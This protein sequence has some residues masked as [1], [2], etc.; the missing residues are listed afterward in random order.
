[1]TNLFF[2]LSLILVLI[3]GMLY[4]K[5]LGA[6]L[7]LRHGTLSHLVRI[8]ILSIAPSLPIYTADPNLLYLMPF[9]FGILWFCIQGSPLARLSLLL[10]LYVISVALSG[11]TTL[12]APNLS[13]HLPLI[14][15]HSFL[16]IIQVFILL[17]LWLL[18]RYLKICTSELPMLSPPLWRVSLLMSL[19]TFS[20][21][22][23]CI[24]F[25]MLQPDWGESALQ[26]AFSHF[27]NLQTLLM[28][29]AIL[30]SACIN[31][32]IIRLL[33]RHEQLLQ[34]DMLYEVNRTYYDQLEQSQLAVRRLRHDLAN[35][36]QTMRELDDASL[37]TYI[38]ALIDTPA[39]QAHTVYCENQIV[40]AVLQN[41]MPQMEQ[42]QITAQ[43]VVSIPKH[44][45]IQPVDLCALF[46][47]GLD[48]AIEACALL[49][50][51]ER[52][53]SVHA[54]A[55]KGLFVLR[56]CNPTV[57]HSPLKADT[58]PQSSKADRI[59]HGHGLPSLQ[60]ISMRY[61]GTFHI[62]RKQGIF[63]LLITIPLAQKI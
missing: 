50:F 48:N 40:N 56:I 63:E 16:Y 47:N 27:F 45:P 24:A 62:T 28:T 51:S 43:Y 55:D 18:F 10:N 17:M 41:K 58:L 13:S 6:F 19:F 12:L 60:E 3:C 57:D 23:L 30:L 15:M 44:L 8:L 7:P 4:E 25:P 36:L 39:M 33:S 2:L 31:L 61:D 35:H 32:Y 29:P 21:L 46:A 59:N 34:A 26:I 5:L 53:L 52:H 9:F 1:M 11:L 14:R 42:H 20:V 49:P 54:R 22:L 37:R 38:D